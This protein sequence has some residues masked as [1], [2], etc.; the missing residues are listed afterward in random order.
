L[1]AGLSSSVFIGLLLAC[2]LSVPGGMSASD[3]QV[4]VGLQ[5]EFLEKDRGSL[6]FFMGTG[7]ESNLSE[8]TMIPSTAL[9]CRND[10]ME[11]LL[12]ALR[13][14]GT[15]PFPIIQGILFNSGNMSIEDYRISAR[16]ERLYFGLAID[17]DFSFETRGIEA[18]YSYLDLIYRVEGLFREPGGGLDIITGTI[19][20]ERELSKIG[21]SLDVELEG[22]LSITS[23]TSVS[24]HLRTPSGESLSDSKSALTFLRSSNRLKV[25]D[26]EA[27]SPLATFFAMV[28]ML[29]VGYGLLGFIWYRERFKGVALILPLFTIALSL[30][31]PWSYFLPG[32]SFYDLGGAS[33]WVFGSVFLLFVGGCNHFHPRPR[34]RSFEEESED[35]PKIGMPEVIYVQ[36]RVLVE[37]RVKMDDVEDSDP[38]EVLEMDRHA[39]FDEIEKAYK[40]RIKE[41]HPDKFAKSPKHIKTAA[42]RET[43]KL[44]IAY[45]KLRR[46]HRK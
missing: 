38:F 36:K 12:R 10:N 33:L 40:A 19:A 27:I 44:N 24:D 9:P 34:L 39:S 23:S 18:E 46:M 11:R 29:L 20:R 43:E 17:V 30:L 5:L 4:K 7:S 13:M 35:Q 2:A 31:L 3:D 25:F 42:K 37:K 16:Q 21:I 8:T 22:K 45:E 15:G 26:C 1:R 41:Y 32:L 28:F 6:H 14:T